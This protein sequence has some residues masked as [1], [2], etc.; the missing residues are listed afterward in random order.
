MRASELI[1]TY[2]AYCP[3]ELSMEGDVVG[4]QVGSLDKEIQ[5]VMITLDV[6]ENTVAEAIE[7]GVDLIITK[8][9]PIFRPVKDLVSSPDRDI[10][11][12]LVKHDI[13]VYVSHTNI[14]VV[15]DG[16]NDWFCQLLDI[17]DTEF[18]T[19]TSDQAGIGRVGTVA[20]QSLE[21][22][23]LKVKTVFNLDSVRLVRYNHDNPIIDRVAI[24]GGSGQGF[25][26]DALKKGAQVLITGDVYYHTGQEMI[27]NGLL[28]I[29]PGHHIEALFIAKIAEKLEVWKKE[30][31]WDVTILQSQASTNPFD[32]L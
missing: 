13:A 7:K 14:D 2:E 4:L 26:K 18:L 16:L 27:T 3:K 8:H 19:V 21:D 30:Q 17:K 22:L 6:R 31:D 1:K 5:K 12:D 28:A 15:E 9:A 25:Y 32:H 11:L 24:C 23:A 29:D 20:P 10:L